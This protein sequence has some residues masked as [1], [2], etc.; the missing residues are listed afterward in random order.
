M[1]KLEETFPKVRWTRPESVHFTLAFLGETCAEGA[2]K[3]AV[4]LRRAGAGIRPF[5]LSFGQAGAFDSWDRP[6]IVWMG[7][8]EGAEPLTRLASVV[9][10]EFITEGLAFDPKPFV[11]HLTLGRVSGRSPQ[12]FQEKVENALRSAQL[13]AMIVVE[14]DLVSSR[15]TAEGPVYTIVQR[16]TLSADTN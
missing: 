4:A 2:E 5:Q 12:G 13:P 3:A 14:L 8:K 9:R 11:P 6:R 7:L 15:T 1:A 10:A 16:P